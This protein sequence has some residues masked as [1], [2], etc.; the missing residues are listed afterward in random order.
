M[1]TMLHQ[2]TGLAQDGPPEPVEPTH[3]LTPREQQI[4][5]TVQDALLNPQQC[6]S[7][8]ACGDP[9]K[10]KAAFVDKSQGWLVGS[11]LRV[12]AVVCCL[13]HAYEYNE[14]KLGRAAL[15]H[16]SLH[17]RSVVL[18]E[19][20]KGMNWPNPV[21]AVA[22]SAFLDQMTAAPGV[23]VADLA[24]KAAR[25]DRVA[26]YAALGAGLVGAALG[27]GLGRLAARKHPQATLIG[28]GGA[29]G[30]G[31]GAGV[32]TFFVTRTV[33][34]SQVKE[35]LAKLKGRTE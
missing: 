28:A 22:F 29:V 23:T 7:R 12:R 3:E 21:D 24:E 19:M 35:E 17:D 13:R 6:P 10:I 15:E 1:L 14:A 2:D 25:I 5:L 9:A 8:E 34:R 26:T 16:L 30:I 32:G 33:M 18:A 27:F 11:D 20:R 31:A 4:A